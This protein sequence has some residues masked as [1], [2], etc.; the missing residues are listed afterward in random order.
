[1]K[2]RNSTPGY[3]QRTTG[4]NEQEIHCNCYLT[5]EA[6]VMDLPIRVCSKYEI[7]C[8]ESWED[9][10]VKSQ[11]EAYTAR[12]CSDLKTYRN[13]H[14]MLRKTWMYRNHVSMFI[15]SI[16]GQRYRHLL[17]CLPGRDKR[18]KSVHHLKY[19]THYP[20]SAVNFSYEYVRKYVKTF[21]VHYV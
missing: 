20:L 3:K 21:Q 15:H 7:R 5:F 19:T 6:L 1:M 10:E 12:V 8:S 9:A 16:C 18:E 4:N 11:C 2:S 17:C 14:C 13:H